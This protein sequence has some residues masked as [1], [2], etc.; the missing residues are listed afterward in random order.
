MEIFKQ[1]PEILRILIATLLGAFLG[2]RRE[3]AA[4]DSKKDRSFMGFRTMVLIC[5]S[6]A[7][8][9]F[10]PLMPWLPAVFFLGLIVFLGIAYYNGAVNMHRIGITSEFSAIVMFWIGVLCGYDQYLI[11]VIVTV[12]LGSLNAFKSDL[13]EFTKTLTI[14]EWKG[15]LQL[16]ILSGILLPFL[17]QTAV[18]PWEVLVPYNV[19]LLV[20]LISGIGF[21]GYFLVKYFGARGGIPLTALLGATVS[22]TAVTTS[23][24]SQSK[25]LKILN[26]FSCGLLIALATM[27][28]K[29]AAIIW[30]LAEPDMKSVA[31]IPLA[32]GCASS[33]MGALFWFKSFKSKDESRIAEKG[34]Q[35]Q[36][37]QPFELKPALFFGVV[38]IL[39]LAAIT[40]AQK[41]FG[42]TGVYGAAILSA[43][44]DIDAIVLSTI[45]SAKLGDLDNNIANKAI[46]M[47]IIVNTLV[48]LVY[49]FFFK[50]YDLLKRVLIPVIISAGVGI[51]VLFLI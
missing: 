6:G 44:V 38:F 32:M 14:S 12:L 41:M 15:A 31:L 18:D 7:V 45:E 42:D 23:I 2:L 49:L 36:L 39:V 11:A 20:M 48:K 1:N 47:S 13:Q 29:I 8:S 43:T 25:K 50:A 37:N 33:I 30:A 4:L 40:F 34:I 5:L 9:T 26:M 10:F 28:F 51:M 27:Q 24:A 35:S 16:L 19:W 17:P 46:V 22:S 21:T 3:M